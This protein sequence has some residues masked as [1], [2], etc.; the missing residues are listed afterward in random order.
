MSP[1]RYIV[2]DEPSLVSLLDGFLA[3]LAADIAGQPWWNPAHALVLAGG[4][5]RGEGGVF[6]TAADAPA[7][8]YNDLEFYLFLGS[9]SAGQAA[10]GW[11]HRWEREGTARLGIDV[12]F[13]ILSAAAFARAA[14]SMFYFDLLQGHRL[15][16][17]NPQVMAAA[18]AHLRQAALIPLSE[19]A[20]L[21]FN[22]GSGLLY[23]QWRLEQG[24]QMEDGFVE[25]NLAKARLALG[26]AVLAAA[27]RHDGSCRERA[28]RLAAG[29][30]PVPDGFAEIMHWHQQGVDFKLCPRHRQP[31]LPALKEQHRELVRRWLEVFLWLESRRLGRPLTRPDDYV[32]FPGRLFPHESVVR[33]LLLHLR[34]RLR[35]GAA[36]PGWTDYPRAALQRALVVALA[37]GPGAETRAA[38]LLASDEANWRDSY[39][40]WWA[41]YN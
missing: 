29:G 32:G 6:R 4:Y 39:R 38:G 8:L 11:C 35:R 21:L 5:G 15:I 23:A 3:E 28:R 33:H 36:L 13:K 19:P 30:F 10:S 18:P 40:R 1:P 24:E 2:E 20:R 31:G 26:D 37:A 27:G 34:D 16:Q 41:C 25:R 9:R 17:G 12:E 7:R 22:R 14:P